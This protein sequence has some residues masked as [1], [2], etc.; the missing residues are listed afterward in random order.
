MTF[1][2]FWRD[3]RNAAG[4]QRPLTELVEKKADKLGYAIARFAENPTCH[5]EKEK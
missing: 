2:P 1:C 3:C 5:E 4:C